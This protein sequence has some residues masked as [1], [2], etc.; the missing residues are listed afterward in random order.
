MFETMTDEQ[1]RSLDIDALETRQAELIA[2]ADSD[3]DAA[4]Y[5]AE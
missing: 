4:E 1:Y 5:K 3:V 2:L